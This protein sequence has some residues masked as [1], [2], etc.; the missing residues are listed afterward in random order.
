M[1][2]APIID[3]DRA[4]RDPHLLGAALGPAETW[5]TWISVLRTA[6]G[7]PLSSG[8]RERFASVAGDREPP[9]KRV[10]EL[11]AVISRRAG[12]TRIA[13]ALATHAAVLQR[14]RLAPGE[15]GYVLL[16][17]ASKDQASLALKY[18]RGFLEASPILRQ[19]IESIS[20]DE[21]AIKGNVVIAVA[22]NSYRTVRGKSLLCV[23]ADEVAYWRDESSAQP[24]VETYRACVP[25][26][27][28]TGGMWIAIS[29][30][31]RRVGLL[32]EKHRDHFG[33]NS[34][35]VLVIQGSTAQ[36]NSTISRD[37]IER[38]K[39][40]DPEAAAAEWE[41]GWREDISG[42]LDDAVVD[43]A[44]DEARPCELPPRSGVSYQA[45]SD[46]S[47]GRHDAFT[48]CIGHREGDKFIAD[49]I[50]GQ[51]PPFDPQA[52]VVSFAALLK[53]Y[54]ISKLR[55]DAYAA[56]WVATAWKAAGINYLRSELPKS[57]LYL[58]SL[59][60][61]VRG[62]VRIPNDVRLTREL[63]LLERRTSRSGKDIVD[64]GRNGS[65][66]F[67]NS[68]CG[69]LNLLTRKSGYDIRGLAGMTD[70]DDSIDTW[71]RRQL[72]NYVLSGGT[73]R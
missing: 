15:T 28:A 8:D 58:E 31:Y 35:D 30:G 24:D 16:I 46:A 62:L 32:F 21:I 18:I 52:T 50:R 66:D 69:L 2:S 37:I 36:F 67:A 55:G 27:A 40:S 71:R 43:G 39:A 42:L 11:W 48:I 41:G 34:D 26:L 56:E 72:V 20:G 10:N 49:V 73:I 38:A 22:A 63:R 45:F 33:R 59:P 64:H 60:L 12:K 13:S 44:I 25:A 61:F 17:A 70:S 57:A 14:H 6:H 4:V 1:T 5:A 68:L 9:S 54:R 23:I 7:L 3:V 47:G 53:E 29:S 19:Q 65:D 51:R